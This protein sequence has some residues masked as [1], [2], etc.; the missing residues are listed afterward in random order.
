VGF[1]FSL[2]RSLNRQM[3]EWNH[4][5]DPKRFRL[6][7]SGRAFVETVA[8]SLVRDT[9][10]K[11]EQDAA[12]ALAAWN[13]RKRRMFRPEHIPIA[14]NR[15]ASENWTPKVAFGVETLDAAWET[16]RL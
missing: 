9:P 4:H 10:S 16:A 6:T 8:D 1:D 3:R 12:D 7:L 14:W 11:D 13:E 2:S 15:L 5:G